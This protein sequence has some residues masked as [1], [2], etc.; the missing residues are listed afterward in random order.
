[1]TG[2]MPTSIE[3]LERVHGPHCTREQA[4]ELLEGLRLAYQS[5][6][7]A[8]QSLVK[9]IV[10]QLERAQKIQEMD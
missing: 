2:M 9:G 7:R 6:S 10:G 1:M 3:S 8:Q 4:A 5:L